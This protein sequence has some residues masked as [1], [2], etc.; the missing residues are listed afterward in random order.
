VHPLHV[1]FEPLLAGK[2]L[3]AVLKRVKSN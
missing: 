1:D 3:R 2:L